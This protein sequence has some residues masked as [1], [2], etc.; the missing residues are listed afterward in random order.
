MII[1]NKHNL[2]PTLVR[3]VSYNNHITNGDISVTQLI[4]A[5]QPRVLRLQNKENI[6]TDANDL[7]LA[8]LGTAFHHL[9][10]LSEYT[11]V[12]AMKISE[13]I[14][15]LENM[16]AENRFSIQA[17]TI[18]NALKD[19]VKSCL[20]AELNRDVLR[21]KNLTYDALGWRLSGTLDRFIISSGTIQDY[22]L[23]SVWAYLNAES[24]SEW[25]AQQNIYAFLLREA[26][27]EVN[28]AEI[29]G[30]YRDWSGGEKMRNKDYPSGRSNTI[31]IEL[32]SHEAMRDYIHKRIA[33]HK[34][35]EENGVVP[36][37]SSK[38]R[39]ASPDTFAVKQKNR[40]KAMRVLHSKAAAEAFIEANSFKYSDMFIEERLGKN[41]KCESYCSVS[42]FCPQYAK[43]LKQQTQEV[44]L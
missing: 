12:E 15:A 44:K 16:A 30:I 42:K 29:I 37:C 20:S 3:A 24:K 21:E 36:E 2:H 40:V 7:I 34:N 32:Y 4:G 41:T 6:E 1:T 33:L 17:T 27:Y 31:P 13:A 28:K 5:P 10:E 14:F 19:F 22:K 39:W 43:I 25:V 26:G 18:S 38:E 35:A 8:G 11:S 23:T 9:L